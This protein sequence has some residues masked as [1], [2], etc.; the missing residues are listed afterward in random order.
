[1]S[2]VTILAFAMC[3]T[4][5]GCSRNNLRRVIDMLGSPDKDK[6]EV[7]HE[8]QG[9]SPGEKRS[10]AE[11]DFNRYF[12]YIAPDKEELLDSDP[13]IYFRQDYDEIVPIEGFDEEKYWREHPLNFDDLPQIETSVNESPSSE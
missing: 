4:L 5:T 8:F 10:H 12:Y 11:E 2:L 7:Y 13:N 3:A 9:Y 1:M 6:P